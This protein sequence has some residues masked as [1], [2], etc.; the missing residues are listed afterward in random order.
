MNNVYVVHMCRWGELENHSY[1][2]GVYTSLSVAEE[3]A[4]DERQY[5]GGKYEGVI[6]ELPI[7]DAFSRRDHLHIVRQ[8]EGPHPLSGK[9]RTQHTIAAYQ[10]LKEKHDVL[11]ALLVKNRL[12]ESEAH[13]EGS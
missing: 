1:V 6:Y 10:L 12:D 11:E 8:P 7:D 9:D 2:I 13:N 5:R 4:E 3:A